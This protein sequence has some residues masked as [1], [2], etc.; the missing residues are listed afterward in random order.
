MC[1]QEQG[2]TFI[3]FS[4][5]NII[6]A[7][8]F[9]ITESGIQHSQ[10]IMCLLIFLTTVNEACF[11]W[12]LC[13]SGYCF[14]SL[15]L[16]RKSSEQQIS[17]WASCVPSAPLPRDVQDRATPKECSKTPS[18]WHT[19]GM[20]TAP[21]TPTGTTKEPKPLRQGAVPRPQRGVSV[22]VSNHPLSP[23]PGFLWSLWHTWE[24]GAVR[25]WI[26]EHSSIPSVS[27]E[28][29]HHEKNLNKTIFFSC[30]WL[31]VV[32]FRGFKI[33]LSESVQLHFVLFHHLNASS[34]SEEIKAI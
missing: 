9:A 23:S 24:A 32:P 6:T 8:P 10:D 14:C 12:S 2:R 3:P 15:Q 30:C 27:L 26:P 31:S 16:Q 19:G 1:F 4:A 28:R 33:H 25:P 29:C 18:P 21:V 7:T 34:W 22:S 5:K 17:P 20:F 11:T 13:S